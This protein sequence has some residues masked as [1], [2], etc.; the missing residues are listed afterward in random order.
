MPDALSQDRLKNCAVHR[1]AVFS[2]NT[3]NSN[4]SLCTCNLQLIC[5]ALNCTSLWVWDTNSM[6]KAPDTAISIWHGTSL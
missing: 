4:A 3:A 2:N 1:T 5:W 6:A